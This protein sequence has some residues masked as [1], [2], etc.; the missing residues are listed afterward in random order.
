MKYFLLQIQ[1]HWMQFQHLSERDELQTTI[2]VR[3]QAADHDTSKLQSRNMH[4]KGKNDLVWEPVFQFVPAF[5]T[6]VKHVLV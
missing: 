1:G 4:K 3:F 2:W 6:V 5:Q